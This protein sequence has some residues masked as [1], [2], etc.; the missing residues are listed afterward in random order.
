ME[1]TLILIKEVFN[2]YH[3]HEPLLECL[4]YTIHMYIENASLKK[5]DIYPYC[6]MASFVM[7]P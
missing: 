5:E 2:N 6:G 1:D 3:A 7:A 4:M